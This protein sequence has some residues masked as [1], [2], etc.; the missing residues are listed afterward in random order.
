MGGSCGIPGVTDGGDNFRGIF[1]GGSYSSCVDDAGTEG[2][3]AIFSVTVF[4]GTCCGAELGYSSIHVHNAQSTIGLE[5][6]KS[7]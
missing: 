3:D 4:V 6:M 7:Y 1:C 5:S 2:T